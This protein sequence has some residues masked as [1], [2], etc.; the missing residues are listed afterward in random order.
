MIG[1]QRWT[2]LILKRICQEKND[3]TG[4][5]PV[6]CSPSVRSFFSDPNISLKLNHQC[7][8]GGNIRL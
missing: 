1:F 3:T 2:N 8:T 7:N 6:A 4:E 5:T